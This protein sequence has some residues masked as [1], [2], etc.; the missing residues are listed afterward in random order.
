M[1]ARSATHTTGNSVLRQVSVKIRVRGLIRGKEFKE[2]QMEVDYAE[3]VLELWERLKVASIEVDSHL[4]TPD[5]YNFVYNHR[6]IFEL[7][8][9]FGSYYVQ[10][11]PHCAFIHA[12]RRQHAAAHRHTRTAWSF[13]VSS[14]ALYRRVLRLP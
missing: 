5:Q 13:G 4:T 3:T 8:R 12:P 6:C 14:H 1:A 2:W 11:L 7:D 10:V 9:T